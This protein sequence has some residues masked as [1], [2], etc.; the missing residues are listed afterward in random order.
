MLAALDGDIEFCSLIVFIGLLLF[1]LNNLM[2]IFK[3]KIQV[4]TD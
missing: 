3:I 2:A 1:S 4:P